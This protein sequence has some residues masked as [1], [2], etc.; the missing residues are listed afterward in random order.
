[1]NRGNKIIIGIAIFISLIVAVIMFLMNR[2]G[3]RVIAKT[4][5]AMSSKE[6]LKNITNGKSIFAEPKDRNELSCDSLMTLLVHSS[7][8]ADKVK[9]GSLVRSDEGER[10]KI[11]VILINQNELGMYIPVT[12]LVLNLKDRVLSEVSPIHRDPI[13]LTYDTAIYNRI[14]R[15]C[16]VIE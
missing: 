15:N 1:M 16:R 9:A 14:A 13:Q 8:L 5:K 2:F 10:G 3:D 6:Y 12:W 11:T 7:S 4:K